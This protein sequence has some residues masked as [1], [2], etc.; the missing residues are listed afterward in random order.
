[1]GT[2]LILSWSQAL[3]LGSQSSKIWWFWVCSHFETV[4]GLSFSLELSNIWISLKVFC[5]GPLS[6]Y[7]KWSSLF[8]WDLTLSILETRNMQVYRILIYLHFQSMTGISQSE[9]LFQ[10]HKTAIL[11]PY[12]GD[13]SKLSTYLTG[14]KGTDFQ[15]TPLT[16]QN[17]ILTFSRVF[18]VPFLGLSES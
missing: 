10:I 18:F 13:D 7:R 6:F 8:P 11:L 5:M 1:M 12:E 15:F 3:V 9:D 2:V 16:T 14:Q 17:F 4:W